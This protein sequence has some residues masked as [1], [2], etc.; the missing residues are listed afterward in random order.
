MRGGAD[1][2]LLF[3]DLSIHG[4]FHDLDSFHQALERLMKMRT[5]AKDRFDQE[6]HCN[7]NFLNTSPVRNFSMQKAVNQLRDKNK[8]EGIM[9]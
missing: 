1:M 7:S 4:Q 3:N 9:T 5:V 2:D 6:V 8:R